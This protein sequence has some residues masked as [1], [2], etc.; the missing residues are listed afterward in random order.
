M[1]KVDNEKCV[2]CGVCIEAC[3]AQAIFMVDGKAEINA[4][5]CVDCSK[6]VSVCPQGA[7]Y[8]DTE[9]QKN[10]G[11]RQGQMPSGS[12]FGMGGG[13]GRGMGR[14]MGR[15]LGRGPRDGRGG[16]KGGGGQR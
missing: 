11:L 2:G 1:F 16:G 5:K 13:S 8:P 15:G 10:S 7:I 3:P 12:D 6:C 9:S 4:D 14:G